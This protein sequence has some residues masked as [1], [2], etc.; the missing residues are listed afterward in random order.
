[1]YESKNKKKKAEEI[2]EL[3]NKQLENAKRFDILCYRA[4]ARIIYGREDI[5]SWV[6]DASKWMEERK[7]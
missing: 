1:M 5:E 4:F 7:K 6:Q 2:C 3:M